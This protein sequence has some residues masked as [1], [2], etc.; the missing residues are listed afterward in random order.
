VTSDAGEAT[1]DRLSDPT[2]LQSE[3]FELLSCTQ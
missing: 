1:L 3:V 2:P